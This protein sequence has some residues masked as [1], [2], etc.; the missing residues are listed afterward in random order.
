MS[1]RT[2]DASSATSLADGSWGYVAAS[3]GFSRNGVCESAVKRL[4][5]RD[6]IVIILRLTLLVLVG[7]QCNSVLRLVWNPGQGR[8]LV[9]YLLWICV[10]FVFAGGVWHASYAV[11]WE[12]CIELRDLVRLTG[13]DS[14]TLL[15]VET[16]SRWWTI[17]LSIVLTFPLAMFARSLGAVPSNA[18]IAGA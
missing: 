8:E 11:C 13:I 15:W 3:P 2:V 9:Q 4:G 14:F 6:V 7:L 17:F 5:S 18:W 12:M 1:S 10:C 16:A